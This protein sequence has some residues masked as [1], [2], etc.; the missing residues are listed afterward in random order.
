MSRGGTDQ[1]RHEAVTF[2]GRVP[3]QSLMVSRI[4]CFNGETLSCALTL[5]HTSYDPHVAVISD[6][7]CVDPNRMF[8]L[9]YIA[10]CSLEHRAFWE[11]RARR[12]LC[13]LRSAKAT[14]THTAPT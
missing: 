7:S 5:G 9:V 6:S 3:V 12:S 11:V 1:G 4:M 2:L 14:E 8:V 13:R 10:Q